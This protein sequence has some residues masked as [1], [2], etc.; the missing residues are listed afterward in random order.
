MS[1]W[2]Y[3]MMT[4]SQRQAINR[5][6]RFYRER[7]RNN[8]VTSV[9]CEVKHMVFVSLTIRT[10]RSDCEKHSPRQIVCEQYAHIFIGRRG[11]IEIA[12]AAYG[13]G[14]RQQEQKHLRHMLS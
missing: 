14:N 3:P 12:D 6:I 5:I 9:R 4:P 10:R 13:L 8:G 2:R 11:R 1:R 7:N